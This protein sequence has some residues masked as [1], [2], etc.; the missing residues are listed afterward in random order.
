V[1]A[2]CQALEYWKIIL[3]MVQQVIST[4]WPN[5]RE[6]VGDPRVRDFMLQSI[7]EIQATSGFITSSRMADTEEGASWDELTEASR[8]CAGGGGDCAR[9][10]ERFTGHAGARASR[11]GRARPSL[12]FF[13]PERNPPRTPPRP[14]SSSSPA[15]I[16]LQPLTTSH[17]PP[18][19]TPSLPAHTP[20]RQEEKVILV[21]HSIAFFI[22]LVTAGHEQVGRVQAY[23]QDPTFASFSWSTKVRA[24]PPN[25]SRATI[26]TTQHRLHGGAGYTAGFGPVSRKRC[27]ASWA[28]GT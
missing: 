13:N 3:G 11:C 19:L 1:F 14:R 24:P 8:C 16:P 26:A 2:R 15:A 17:L 6:L 4:Y 10:R 22:Y 7:N 9:G 5:T 21:T 23:A 20:I 18:P 28:S 25:A 12:G 27:S